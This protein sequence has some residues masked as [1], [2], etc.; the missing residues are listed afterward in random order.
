MKYPHLVFEVSGAEKDLPQKDKLEQYL[1]E[2]EPGW[3]KIEN[4]VMASFEKVTNSH[5]LEN[6]S[7]DIKCTF[8]AVGV[9][10][11]HPL[12]LHY[13]LVDNWAEK[14]GIKYKVKDFETTVADLI[15]ELSH[16]FH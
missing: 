3:V 15:H 8:I 1:Q 2:F 12:E 6:K 5:W 4:G 11:S 16:I 7:N 14:L 9:S 13:L 10:K